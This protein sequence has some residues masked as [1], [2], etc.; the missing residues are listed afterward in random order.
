MATHDSFSPPTH[1]K[2]CAA[3][4]L[5]HVM[6]TSALRQWHVTRHPPHSTRP[7]TLAQP[8]RRFILGSTSDK[9][10]STIQF[11]LWELSQSSFCYD[12]DHQH[13][14]KEEELAFIRTVFI[15]LE[16]HLFKQS[17][18]PAI[19]EYNKGQ[20]PTCISII[21][22]IIITWF[23]SR[24]FRESSQRRWK[25]ENTRPHTLAQPH[26]VLNSIHWFGVLNCMITVTWLSAD[27]RIAL[28][29]SFFIHFISVNMH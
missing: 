23:I 17:T 15:V 4:L 19:Y 24:Q 7:H 8:Y 3:V 2:N 22:I 20:Q 13:S 25:Y 14:R 28:Y 21:I 29:L 26:T 16:Q 9:G 12:S 1:I 18:L 11:C 10:R 6:P 27:I 5:H